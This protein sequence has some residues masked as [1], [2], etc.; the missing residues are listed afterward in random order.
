MIRLLALLVVLTLPLRAADFAALKTQAEQLYGEQSYAKAHELY[1][2]AAEPPADEKRWI[3][4]RLADTLWRS[5]AATKTA[6]TTKFEE[7]QRGLEAV[8]REVTRE[9]DR[10]RAWAE[11]QESLGDFFW[12]RQN[13]RNWGEALPHYRAALDWWAGA[14]EVDL[15]RERYLVMIWNMARPPEARPHE[16]YGNMGNWLPLELLDDALYGYAQWMERYG[17][18][19]ARENGGWQNEPDYNKALE[20]YRRIVRDFKKGE[21]RY[22][23]NAQQ[24]IAE[25]T[26]TRVGVNVSNVFLPESQVQFSVNWRNA[27]KIEFAL[28]PVSLPRNV[29][30]GG[31]DDSLNDW[32]QRIDLEKTETIKRWTKQTGDTGVHKPG[33]ETIRY[34]GALAPGAYVIEARAGGE[35]AR[36]LVLVSD[37]AVVLKT[38]G[39]QALTY[40]CN[41]LDGSPRKNA[42]VRI[43]ECWRVGNKWRWQEQDGKTNAD[44]IATFFPHGGPRPAAGARARE[45]RRPRGVCLER[46]SL[47]PP[48]RSALE[49]LRLH[50]PSGVSA[51]GD[52]ALEKIH[53]E[54]L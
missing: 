16:S 52:G 17:R 7:A 18:F 53:G 21:T 37:A 54:A 4:M 8:I 43:I 39:Q 9:E 29:Q 38:S 50:R 42:M 24:Q 23:D 34:E 45:R 25:I 26:G 27:K 12:S 15:A 19:V 5:Q 33:S 49:N 20:L 41:A 14:R 51:G 48:P 10:D 46:R 31:E 35:K 28:H 22:Y 36:D 44:G 30:T 6:D 32:V 40:V 11:A 3:A 2:Q 47:G 1:A 13:A